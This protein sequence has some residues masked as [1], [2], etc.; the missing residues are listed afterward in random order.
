MRGAGQTVEL[1][2]VHCLPDGDTAT[3]LPC[4]CIPHNTEA[5]QEEARRLGRWDTQ[6]A[7]GSDATHLCAVPHRLPHGGFIVAPV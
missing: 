5:Y 6:D 1:R 7:R 3:G 2:E 4:H